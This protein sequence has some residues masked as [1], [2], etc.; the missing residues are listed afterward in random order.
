MQVLKSLSGGRRRFRGGEGEEQPSLEEAGKKLE[1]AKAALEEAQQ[2]CPQESYDA[3]TNAL[4]AVKAATE[5][6]TAGGGRR[7][8]RRRSSSSSSSSTS[9]R[10]RSARRSRRRR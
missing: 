1:A 2:T 6:T 3:V 10:R 9:R 8:S 7:R 4:A 5:P